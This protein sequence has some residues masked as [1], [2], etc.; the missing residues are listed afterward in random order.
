MRL[1]TGDEV[2]GVLLVTGD[3]VE[4]V[5]LVTG[6]EV[7]GVLLVTGDEVEGVLLVTWEAGRG[8]V[9]LVLVAEGVLLVTSVEEGWEVL[10][11]VEVS[12][13]GVLL[14]T[15][16]AVGL[17][18]VGGDVDLVKLVDLV[19]GGECEAGEVF[20]VVL[21]EV[22]S[23]VGLVTRGVVDL[24]LEVG[25]ATGAGDGEAGEVGERVGGATSPVGDWGSAE[26]PSLLLS[27]A[28]TLCFFF[29][30][31]THTHTHS[32]HIQYTE[33]LVG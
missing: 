23:S 13:Q 12:V 28:L 8:K 18:L 7:E 19:V 24:S 30:T 15:G 14:V 22:V 6:D 3:E 2:E 29:C 27:R 4:G 21:V 11:G 33:E 16:V 26:L 17:V 32:T 9:C 1:V 25:V 10:F 31:H 5:R 20:V